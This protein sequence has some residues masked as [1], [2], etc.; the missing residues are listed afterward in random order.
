MILILVLSALY[1]SKSGVQLESWLQLSSAG[2][3]VLCYQHRVAFLGTLSCSAA[4]KE[5]AG[6]LRLPVPGLLPH[7]SVPLL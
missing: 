5:A 2:L 6:K 4:L 7:V 1:Q 3:A